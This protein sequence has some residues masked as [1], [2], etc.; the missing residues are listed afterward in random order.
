MKLRL[1]ALMSL[2][3]VLSAC[4]TA[5]Q[6]V[7]V[8]EG[9]SVPTRQPTVIAPTAQAQ[10]APPDA[11]RPAP[12]GLSMAFAAAQG[13]PLAIG[14]R[15]SGALDNTRAAQLHT[16][17]GQAGQR[18]DVLLEQQDNDLDPYIL[19][20]APDG[21]EL[22]F[23]DD[24]DFNSLNSALLGAELPESGTYTLVAT[25][26]R[27]QFGFSTGRYSLEIR[28]AANADTNVIPARRTS[29]GLTQSGTLNG[30]S[31]RY[32]F[33]ATARD[34]ID[35]SV[36]KT[37]GDLDPNIILTDS[38]GNEI[39]ANDDIN[40]FTNFDAAIVGYTLPASGFYTVIVEASKNDSAFSG[41]FEL[42]L[43]RAD[44]PPTPPNIYPAYLDYGLSRTL[45]G[46]Q[47]GI[48]NTGFY[49]GGFGDNSHA[50]SA[51]TFLTF[52]LPPKPEGE[53]VSATLD[54][55][56]CVWDGEP[57]GEYEVYTEAYTFLDAAT[58]QDPPPFL[59]SPLM[60]FGMNE[61]GTSRVTEF[62]RDAY[63]RG[64]TRLQYRIRPRNLNPGGTRN[65]VMAFLQPRLWV[66][67]R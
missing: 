37:S 1:I 7:A 35:I 15:V 48:L 49:I 64:E 32:T 21:R 47:Q 57:V 53:I 44:T 17:E 24:R 18:I 66:E 14:E 59:E 11:N 22:Y 55:G 4:G 26:W 31:L 27:Q 58:P 5:P 16:F 65:E 39:A 62:V 56:M 2:I 29:Y 9:V 61:C 50:A 42:R 52:L 10:A 60:V 63:E 12:Q 36:R 38:L 33:A 6:G 34:V 20:L 19:M 67:T 51:Q 13:A 28:P 8:F 25:R 40:P 43:D 54:I 30:D 41:D 45:L 46:N 3:T 23:N